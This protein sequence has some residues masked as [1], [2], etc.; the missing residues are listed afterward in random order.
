MLRIKPD[1]HD[2][3]ESIV[4]DAFASPYPRLRPVAIEHAKKHLGI[5]DLD[6]LAKELGFSRQSF[7]RVRRGEYDIR[8]SHALRVCQALNWPL[9]R[10]FEVPLALSREDGHRA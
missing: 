8:L 6:A 2:P 3:L 4:V 1:T 10:V 5:W 9:Y 7:W